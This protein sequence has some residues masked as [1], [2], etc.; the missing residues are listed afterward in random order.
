MISTNGLIIMAK[1]LASTSINSDAFTYADAM[2]SPQRDD[3]KGAMEEEC[4][5]IPPNNTFTTVN[6][7]EARELRVK[8]IGS[9]WVYK[10]KHN[11][12]GTIGYKAHRVIIG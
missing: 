7:R 12:E 6:T 1:V 3:W 4:T 10:M 8:P 2:D 9:K 5:S 11:S